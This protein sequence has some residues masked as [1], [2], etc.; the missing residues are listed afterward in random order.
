MGDEVLTL[1]E[2]IEYLK[3]RPDR[4]FRIGLERPHSDRGDYSQVAFSATTPIQARELLKSVEGFIGQEFEGYK[5]GATYKIARKSLAFLG[6]W[7]DCG[8]PITA[9]LMNALLFDPPSQTEESEEIALLKSILEDATQVAIE[10]QNL[11]QKKDW[12]QLSEFST[13]F[14]MHINNL[15][16]HIE[17]MNQKRE[18]SIREQALKSAVKEFVS[19]VKGESKDEILKRLQE[20][21]AESEG[22]NDL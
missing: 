12:S 20:V 4:W 5:D 11:L 15:P 18:T 14:S 3:D 17:R 21:F 16:Y 8:T 1:E 6:G 9:E 22:E 19:K 10:T 13:H 2:L 7:G